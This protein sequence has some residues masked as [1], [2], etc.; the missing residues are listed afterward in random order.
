MKIWHQ[1]SVD[2]DNYP[3]YRASMRR[4]YQAV[5]PP[6]TEMHFVGVP[7]ATCWPG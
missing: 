5:L 2:L 6:E 4:H 3:L 1:S 7:V